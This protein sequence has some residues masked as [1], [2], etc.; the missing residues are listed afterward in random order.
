M[1]F[2]AFAP[3]QTTGDVFADAPGNAKR[4]VASGFV[5]PSRIGIFVRDAVGERDPS[6]GADFCAYSALDGVYGTITLAPL[7]GTDDPKAALASDFEEQ[8][9][10]GGRKIAE[11]PIKIAGA[12]VYART[13]QTSS[14][15]SIHYRVQFAAG[16]AGAWSVQATME[17]ASPRDD[18]IER[19]FLET[20]YAAAFRT[21]GR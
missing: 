15:A 4:H 9:G 11:D 10:T 21:L 13:Y 1:A 2:P 20:V 8:E 18:R 12:S 17:Y 5:C 3:A 6:A 14:L 7:S 19:E 16:G